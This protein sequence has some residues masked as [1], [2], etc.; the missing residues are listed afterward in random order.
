MIII[1]FVGI[2]GASLWVPASILSIFAIKH[3]GMTIAQGVWSGVTSNN[4]YYVQ[5]IGYD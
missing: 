3:A 1:F 4:I 5:Y 2:V